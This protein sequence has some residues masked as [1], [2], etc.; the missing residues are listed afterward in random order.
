MYTS[1][2]LYFTKDGIYDIYYCFKKFYVFESFQEYLFLN[3][4][5]TTFIRLKLRL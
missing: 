3:I 1:D 4:F 2:V 5:S